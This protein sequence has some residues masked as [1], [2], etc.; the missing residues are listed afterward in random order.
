MP[1]ITHTDLVRYINLKLAALGQPTSHTTADAQF[2]NIAGP[3][4]RNY[5][6]KDQ[7]LGGRLCPA[8]TRIQDFL[9]DYLRDVCPSGVARLPA[10]T[11]ILD[12]EG[13]ARIVSLPAQGDS[14]SSPFLNSYRVPQG[15][16][17]NPKSDRRTTQGLFQIVEGGLPVPADKIPVPKHVFAAL[18]AAALK[19]P[20]DVLALPFT[21]DQQQQ[22]RC[23]VS[24]LLRPPVCPATAREPQKTME[25]RFLA[26]ASLVSNLDF[27]ESIFGNGGDPYLPENDA[28]LDALHWTG[29]T[30]CVVLAPHLV[31]IR[32][33]DAGFADAAD[34]EL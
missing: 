9:D 32:K 15:I 11:L 2:L 14:F 1:T 31:G 27:V 25:I 5:Y 6:Q 29:N 22:A 33:K 10:G 13:M 24:L 28:A 12:R 23:F 34:D 19:P 26:P 4:L 17:H 18:W 8:D 21:A 30:G 3:L 20:D 16:L 7:L